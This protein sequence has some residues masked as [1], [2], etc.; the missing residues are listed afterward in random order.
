VADVSRAHMSER[1]SNDRVNIEMDRM[2]YIVNCSTSYGTLQ[3]TSVR[4]TYFLE[5]IIK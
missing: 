4:I 3:Q 2:R 5:K 1:L